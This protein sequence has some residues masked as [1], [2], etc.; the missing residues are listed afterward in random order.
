VLEAWLRHVTLHG[1]LTG[2][3]GGMHS[4]SCGRTHNAPDPCPVH[5]QPDTFAREKHDAMRQGRTA[6]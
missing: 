4:R 6:P 1:I 2:N 3:R 5:G